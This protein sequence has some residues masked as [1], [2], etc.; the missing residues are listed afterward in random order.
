MSFPEK[1][2]GQGIMIG[3]KIM[4]QGNYDLYIQ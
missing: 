2:K 1:I 4:G 3:K